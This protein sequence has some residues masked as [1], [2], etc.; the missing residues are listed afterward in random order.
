M[1]MACV[2]A[3]AGLYVCLSFRSFVWRERRVLFLFNSPLF[4]PP[5]KYQGSRPVP[6]HVSIELLPFPS[7]RQSIPMYFF[8]R[9]THPQYPSRVILIVGNA[10]RTIPSPSL[11]VKSRVRLLAVRSRRGFR[12]AHI[13]PAH[14]VGDLVLSLVFLLGLLALLMPDPEH[15]ACHNGRCC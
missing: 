5:T 8:L 6:R 7:P 15:D 11:G 14:E 1:S 10:A 4:R 12:L 3:C 2:G 13:A 9:K